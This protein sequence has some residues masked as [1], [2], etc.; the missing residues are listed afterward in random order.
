MMNK[1]F[2]SLV[3]VF[4]ILLMILAASCTTPTEDDF[5]G[6]PLL[7][8]DG[9]LPMDSN[10]YYHLVLNPNTNQ[11]IHTIGGNVSNIYEPTKIDWES[12]LSWEYNGE[13]VPTINSASYVQKDGTI[14]TV[15]APIF[16]MKNDTLVVYATVNE[17]NIIRSI[18]IVLE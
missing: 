10:G 14:N 16:G 17:W 3:I 5:F 1:L 8:L 18:S 4:L 11:T 6:E 9:R 13:L 2:D 12:N 15:I 7:E